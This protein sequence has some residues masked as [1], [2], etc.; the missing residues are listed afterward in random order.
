[1]YK[2]HKFERFWICAPVYQSP[3][4]KPNRL[5]VNRGS[6]GLYFTVYLFI[7]AP[8]GGVSL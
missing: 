2:T 7:P 6:Y 3:L 4:G 5:R 1:M 8:M